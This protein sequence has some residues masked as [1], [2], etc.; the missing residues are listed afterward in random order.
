M[1]LVIKEYQKVKNKAVM[2]YGI[3]IQCYGKNDYGASILG[4][5]HFNFYKGELIGEV[6]KYDWF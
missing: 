1:N 5:Y 2:Y 4:N 3:S 6:N